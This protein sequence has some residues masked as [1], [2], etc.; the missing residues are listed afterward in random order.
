MHKL[1]I[2]TAWDEAHGALRRDGRLFVPLA[3]AFLVVPGVLLDLAMPRQGAQPGAPGA[4]WLLLFVAVI[5]IGLLGQLAIQWLAL[6]PGTPV[7]DAIERAARRVPW[8][9]AAGVM[10][11]V[12]IAL[13][14]LPLVMQIAANPKSP[15]PGAAAALLLA[16][17]LLLIPAARLILMSAA[18]VA[19][20]LGPVAMIKRSWTLTRGSTLRLYGLLLLFCV[21][22]LVVMLAVQS[23]VGSLVIVALGQPEPW[24]VSALLISLAV[25]LAQAAVSV[26][27]TILFARLYAQAAGG[28]AKS[29]T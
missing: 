22:I 19:E 29:G 11:A 1:S 16:I 8:V 12:P 13:L 27:L 24:T 17:P 6:S 21:A 7:R 26:P 23:V 4:G 25:Q 3:L 10:L 15:P 28:A 18:A 5:V 9:F 20:E 2:S 14:L